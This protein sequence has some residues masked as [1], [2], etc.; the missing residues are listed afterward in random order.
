MTK[1]ALLTGGSRGIGRATANLLREREWNVVTPTR[2][3]VD[4]TDLNDVFVYS[5]DVMRR[6][7]LGI[8]AFDAVVFCHGEWYARSPWYETS[9]PDTRDPAKMWYRQYTMR[10]FA[11]M[12]FVQFLLRCDPRHHPESVTMVSSARAFIGGVD[13]GAYS[14]ACAAQV[15]LMQGYAR[16]YAGTRFNCVCPGLTDTDMAEEVI[17]TGG[18]KPDAVAQPPEVVAAEIV[19]LI[20]DGESSGK[21]VRVVDGVASEAKWSW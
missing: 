5:A 18:A 19:R 12:L 10:V 20:E 15:S 7:Q 1:T 13:S 9:N 11:P 21:V 3:D 4:W 8:L 17:E 2:G 14:A 6:F 16:E